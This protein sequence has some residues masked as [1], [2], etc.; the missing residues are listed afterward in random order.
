MAINI[1]VRFGGFSGTLDIDT[2]LS[3]IS[4]NPVQNKVI[5]N[6]LDALELISEYAKGYADMMYNERGNLIKGFLGNRAINFSTKEIEYVYE[7]IYSISLPIPVR[8]NNISSNAKEWTDSIKWAAWVALDSNFVPIRA[9]KKNTYEYKDGEEYVIFNFVKQ[10]RIAYYGDT[11]YGEKYNHAGVISSQ[12]VSLSL[13]VK[14]DFDRNL[15]TIPSG[16]AFSSAPTS[17]LYNGAEIDFSKYA[18]NSFS[19]F[20]NRDTKDIYIQ[21]SIEFDNSNYDYYI[22]SVWA[23]IGKCYGF[24]ND[25][26]I[27]KGGGVVTERTAQVGALVLGNMYIDTNNMTIR[28]TGTNARVYSFDGREYKIQNIDTLIDIPTTNIVAIVVS[29]KGILTVKNISS[30]SINDI[31]ISY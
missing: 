29:D 31:I 24:A 18:N 2:E 22:G 15:L 9:G 11:I 13:D 1:I 10:N 17:F 20:I 30:V 8:G 3:T 5:T 6:K 23:D 7:S 12:L 19:I 14:I 21:N 28:I 26:T 16:F 25:P 4:E 27:I